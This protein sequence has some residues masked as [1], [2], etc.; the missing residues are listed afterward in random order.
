M[1]K[2]TNYT[3][4]ENTDALTKLR[5]F[6]WTLDEKNNAILTWEWPQNRLVKLMFIFEWADDGV[7]VPDI[8]ILLNNGHPHEVV[9]R[10]LATRFMASITGKC[11]YIA[12]PAYF[13]DE[14][15]ITVCKP[16]YNTDWLFQKVTV[17]TA[18]EYKQLPLSHF[19]KATIRVNLDDSSQMPLVTQIL[20]YAIFEQG[21]KIGEYPLDI[22][23][24]SGVCGVYLKKE[25][26][27]KFVLDE[28]YSHLFNIR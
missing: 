4:I 3:I 17:T 27:I 23:A 14:R 7:E 19:Q 9:T 15:G 16:T 25:Q 8:E 26:T 18:V 11:K 20:K 24:C 5:K 1:N 10:D 28:A 21:Y 22:M 13:N 12:V 6:E 2:T